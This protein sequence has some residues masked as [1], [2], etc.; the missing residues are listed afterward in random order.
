M[1]RRMRF[2]N[3]ANASA[4]W[5]VSRSGNA[6]PTRCGS[7]PNVPSTAGCQ[8]TARPE[9]STRV[10]TESW[11]SGGGCLREAAF[12]ERLGRSLV[13]R[14]ASADRHWC[15]LL[16][17]RAGRAPDESHRLRSLRARGS[18]ERSPR[19]PPKLRRAAHDRTV[20]ASPGE[21]LLFRAGGRARV[22]RGF[23]QLRPAASFQGAAIHRA[24]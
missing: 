20:L 10:S 16:S 19:G 3:S 2:V 9:S 18:S 11:T 21:H 17:S 1:T 23:D 24:L 12:V 14:R 22:D 13:V 6:S 8:L 7:W 4:P 15:V 5:P